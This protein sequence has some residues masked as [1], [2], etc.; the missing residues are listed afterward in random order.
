LRHVVP[1]LAGQGDGLEYVTLT[2]HEGSQV[3]GPFD[4][5]VVTVPSMP[6]TFWEQAGLPWYARKLRAQ[7][8]YSHSECAPMWSP[9]VLLHI[10]EDP[11]VRWQ[12]APSTTTREHLRRLYQRLVMRRS[13]YN[14]RPVVTCSD[15]IASALRERFGPDLFITATVPLG[16]DL[17]IF[18]PSGAEPGDDAVFHLGSAEPR[19]NSVL[20]VDAYARALTTVP[21]LPDL[22]IGGNLGENARLVRCTANELGITSRVQLLGYISDEQLRQRYA[23]S[24]M[25]VQPARYEGFGLQ[26]LEA[27]A[28]GAALIVFP[29]PAVQEVVAGAATVVP[30]KTAAALAD[31]I[32][33]LWSDG[34]L[35][36]SLREAGPKRA[37]GYT[38]AATAK[39]LHELLLQ[40]LRDESGRGLGEQRSDLHG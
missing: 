29:E 36:A 34:S 13:L 6:K 30:E 3:L 31:A 10:P 16:V 25:C 19:D 4:G 12:G 21:E 23:H 20:V 8:I 14:A 39:K 38:W 11:Y 27:L 40:S 37:A 1:L 17:D 32:V 35:R 18:Y 7:A 22:L 28:C 15:A 2:T 33:K 9:P 5:E 26:P 24:C